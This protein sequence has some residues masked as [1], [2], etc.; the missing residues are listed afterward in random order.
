M[1]RF[2]MFALAAGLSMPAAA[3]TPAQ[4]AAQTPRPAQTPASQD[5]MKHDAM[6]VTTDADF[7]NKVAE[8]GMKEVEVAK[9]AADKSANTDVKAFAQRLVTD[10]SKA[11]DEV[12]KLAKDENVTLKMDPTKPMKADHGDMT[13]GDHATMH[14]GV[15][16]LKTLEG[17]AFDRAFIDQMVKDHQDAVDLFTKWA[18]SGKDADVKEWAGKKLPTLKEHLQMAKDLQQKISR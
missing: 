13:K 4:T 18:D 10:H 6:P 16:N 15:T 17:A 14:A 11:N 2:V 1:S 12:V 9:L 8:S 7:L 5:S 3:Q